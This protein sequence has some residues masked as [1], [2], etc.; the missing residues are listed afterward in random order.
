MALERVR[1]CI[2]HCDLRKCV[3]EGGLYSKSYVIARED[4]VHR[5][6]NAAIDAPVFSGDFN[7]DFAYGAVY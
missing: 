6:P 4:V 5:V 2:D 7:D 1:E 3:D